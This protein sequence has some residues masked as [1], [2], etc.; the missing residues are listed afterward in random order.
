MSLQ[1]RLTLFFVLIVILLGLAAISRS[2]TG[3]KASSW[4]VCAFWV[5][6][7]GTV[8]GILGQGVDGLVG[9]GAAQPGVL[10]IVDDLP[11]A[12]RPLPQYHPSGTRRASD[13]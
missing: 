10:G 7:I 1:R 3:E 6:V 8:F 4:G 9:P 2:I 13:V 12:L 11:G 5:G